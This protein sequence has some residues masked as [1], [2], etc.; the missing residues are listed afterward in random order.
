MET[1]KKSSE[2]TPQAA[3]MWLVIGAFR[4]ALRE[5]G[6]RGI[7]SGEMY[8]IVMG[9]MSLDT[10]TGIIEAMKML[11]MVKESNH[12]LTITEAHK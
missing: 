4:D 3:A 7:P 8:A 12:L 2:M 11:G 6:D 1:E 9:K 5:A 10:Y